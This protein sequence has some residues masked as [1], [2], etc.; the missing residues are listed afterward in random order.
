MYCLY[1]NGII[2]LSN[3]TH[4]LNE[5]DHIEISDDNVIVLDNE[6]KIS[7]NEETR[8]SYG[9]KV[10]S[11]NGDIIERIELRLLVIPLM[12]ESIKY[13]KDAIDNRNVFDSW[14]GEFEYLIAMIY[15][16]ELNNPLEASRYYM[17]AKKKRF[18]F[19][20]IRKR[21]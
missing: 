8:L 14:D 7:L 18:N 11:S 16:L 9:R 19:E 10:E 17:E 1:G 6:E 12:E 21:A 4:P 20:L 5:F 2:D 13:Y 15:E 3:L